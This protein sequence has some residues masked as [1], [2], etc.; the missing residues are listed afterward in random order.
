MKLTIT[1]CEDVIPGWWIIERAEHDG[2]EWIHEM[3]SDRSELRTSARFSDADVEG[4]DY[5]MLAIADTIEKRRYAAMKRCAV[6]A[7]TTPVRFWSPRNSRTRGECTV[8]EADDLAKLIRAK[9]KVPAKE[10]A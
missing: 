2:R 6:D 10:P 5:E 4:Y 8:A 9:I 1:S 3:G 7:R